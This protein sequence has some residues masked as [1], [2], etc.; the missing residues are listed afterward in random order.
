MCVHDKGRDKGVNK[1]ENGDASRQLINFQK[2][3]ISFSSNMSKELKDEIYSFF[4]VPRIE[5]HGKYL[6]LPSL[7]RKN[8]K[9]VFSFIKDSLGED[10]RLEEENVV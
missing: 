4:Q 8:K 3:S 9:E 1:A 6:G 7:V 5:D 10:T 2:S